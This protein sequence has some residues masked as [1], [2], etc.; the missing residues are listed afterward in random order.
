MANGKCSVPRHPHQN[1]RLH[2]NI[3]EFVHE[4][5]AILSLLFTIHVQF[6]S[7]S[8]VTGYVLRIFEKKKKKKSHIPNKKVNTWYMMNIECQIFV[9]QSKNPHEK[10]LQ[11]IKCHQFCFNVCLFRLKFPCSHFYGKLILWPAIYNTIGVVGNRQTVGF[12]V[13]QNIGHNEMEQL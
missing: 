5:D 7:L 9:N 4:S 10:F 1:C 2:Q 13:R 3:S 8:D 6:T 11:G 12:F